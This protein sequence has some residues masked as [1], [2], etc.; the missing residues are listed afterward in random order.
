M[1]SR[2]WLLRHAESEWNATGRWQG[3]ADPPLSARGE[4]QAA[5]AAV[6]VARALA[7][8]RIERLY[9][10]TLERA[11]ATARAVGEKLALEPI[12]VA[13][14]EEL[15]VGRWSGFSTADIRKLEP[16]RLAAF[17]SG[18]LDAR[19]GGGESRRELRERVA[20]TLSSL[21][22]KDRSVGILCVV[23]LGV[24]RVAAPGAEPKNGELVRARFEDLDGP[25][26]EASQRQQAPL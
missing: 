18:D 26:T 9:C 15:D 16:E 2:L 6:E 11:A 5:L 13:G 23:H 7:G 17:E 21:A 8:E 12:A 22:P 20:R 25:L 4:Q 10:S 24:I 19:P 14:L 1:S 3:R